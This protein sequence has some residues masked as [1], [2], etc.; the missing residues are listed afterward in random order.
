MKILQICHENWS[1]K[2]QIDSDFEWFFLDPQSDA[3][4]DANLAGIFEVV[5]ISSFISSADLEL[6]S[7]LLLPYTIIIDKSLQ[8]QFDESFANFLK[9]KAPEFVDISD[10]QTLINQIP[11]MFFSGQFGDKLLPRKILFSPFH[12]EKVWFE[13]TKYISTDIDFG[14]TSKQLLFWK[15]SIPYESNWDMS[16]WPEFIHSEGC[17]VEFDIQFYVTDNPN[18]IYFKK[19]YTESELQEP[20]HFSQPQSGYIV[21]SVFASGK[22]RIKMG[23]IHYR[24]NR[25]GLGEFIPGGKRLVDKNREEL[26]YY[27]HPC[28]LKPPFNIYFGDYQKTTEGFESMSLMKNLAHPFLI[29]T[30]PRLEGGSFYIGSA[31]LEKKVENVIAEHMKMLNITAKDVILSGLSMGS[32]AAL[33]Y[34]FRLEPLAIIVGKPILDLQYVADRVRLNRP[35]DFLTILDIVEF[36]NKTDEQD[37]LIPLVQFQEDMKTSWAAGSGFGDTKLYLARMIQDDYDDMAYYHLLETQSGKETTIIS[38][39]FQG[40]HNDQETTILIWFQNQYVKVLR[41]YEKIQKGE[42]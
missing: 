17:F 39:G 20:I 9:M 40:R 32:F 30:D 6:L 7:P 16:I 38:R 18:T 24:H 23:P 2:Y 28:N 13:G 21:C 25:L 26:F 3:A 14:D 4:F 22:G 33:Y 31:E 35:Y 12:K 27:F 11:K 5:I 1:Q 42:G 15:L 19:R 37:R 34:G 8:V 41:E 10:P 36:W 29:F